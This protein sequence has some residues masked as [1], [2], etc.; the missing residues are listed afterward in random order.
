MI[1]TLDEAL[2]KAIQAH[3][4]GQQQEA[5]RL[6]TAVL[7]AQPKNPDANHN[8]GLLGVSIGKLQ[9]ALPFFK[10][11]LEANPNIRQ[12]W[13]S[14]ID[15]LI[16]LDRLAEAK[17]AMKQAKDKGAKGEAFDQ[18]EQRLTVPHEMPT[19][20]DM[21]ND[22]V[23]AKFPNNKRAIDGIRSLSGQ[24]ID[25]SS[26]VQNPTQD[27]LQPLINLFSQGQLQQVLDQIETS[28]EMAKFSGQTPSITF[29]PLG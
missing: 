4:A 11:A 5:D 24:L 3:K 18:L 6:Y 27:Q 25:K 17:G 22:D 9:E 26:N 20:A 16:K 29:T 21:H 23:L 2:Q 1:V 7:K 19:E 14:Y 13:L 28:D 12:F 8:M 10:T 15:T